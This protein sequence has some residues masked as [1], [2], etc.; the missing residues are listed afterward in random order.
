MT[1]TTKYLLLML[2]TILLGTYFYISWC[3]ECRASITEEPPKEA[4][5]PKTPEPT[6]FPF[7]FSDGA[8][9]FNENDNYNFNASSSKILMPLDTSMEA[10]ITSLK[11]FLSE[12]AGKVINIIGYYNSA[13]YM[14][15][16]YRYRFPLA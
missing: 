11:N 10:G 1:R 2:L 14:T 6:S 13:K 15:K 12:N 9:A 5:I 3:S 16:I 8:Y 4:L 7:A